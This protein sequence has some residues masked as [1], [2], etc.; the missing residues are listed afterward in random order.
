VP[1]PPIVFV[2]PG[3]LA[4]LTGGY[5]YDRHIIDGLRADGQDVTVMSLG[6][7][8]PWPDAATLDHAAGQIA[9]IADGATVVADGLALGVIPDIVARHARRLHWVALVHHPLALETGLSAARAQQLFDSERRALAAVSR[10]IVTSPA[11]A[12]ALEPYGVAASCIEVIEP[13]THAVLLAHGSA[14]GSVQSPSRSDSARADHDGLSLLCVATVTPRKGHDI[15]IDALA[16]L[17]DRPW[18]LDCVG[19]LTRDAAAAHALRQAIARHGLV[20]RVWLH[21]EVSEARLAAH[22]AQADA[23]VLASFHEGYGMVLSEALAHGLPIVSTRA[24]AIPDTVP[25]GAGLLVP[26]GDAAAL[27][28]AL[29]R[30]MDEPALRASLAAGAQAARAHLPGWP[31]AVSRFAQALRAVARPA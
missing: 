26:P 6:G 7:G 21:G 14:H 31:Q 28:V 18:R 25:A 16:G 27:R 19:S 20:E 23:F 17:R 3:D 30:L 1:L 5:A 4:S 15:L 9:A 2:I 12:L 8:F 29:A 10:V 11:T 13:G 24:G 22:Y